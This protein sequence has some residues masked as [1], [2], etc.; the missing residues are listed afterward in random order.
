MVSE[1][2]GFTEVIGL[3]FA[4]KGNK[5]DN[6]SVIVIKTSWLRAFSLKSGLLC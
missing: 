1:A 4:E 6:D 3:A 5:D 2:V